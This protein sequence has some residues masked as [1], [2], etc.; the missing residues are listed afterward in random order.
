VASEGRPGDVLILP[1]GDEASPGTRLRP[2]AYRSFLERRGYRV[3]V[4]FPLGAD[5]N[6]LRRRRLLRPLE[7]VRDLRAASKADLVVVYRKTFPGP[8]ARWLRRLAPRVIYE[9]DDAVYLPSRGEPQDERSRARYLANF[10]TTVAAA[11]WVVAGN[12]HLAE[13]A[14]H[15]RTEI[16]PT[17]VDL[18]VFRPR[19][20]TGQPERCV[21]GW[22]GTHGNLPEWAGLLGVFEHVVAARPGVRLKVVSDG[23]PPSTPLPLEVERF[24]VERE[25]ACL[26]AFDIGLMPLADTPWNRGKCSYKALQCMA[27]GLPVVLSP[28]GMNR[29]VVEHGVTGLFAATDEEWAEAILRL[30]DDRELR[31]RL[32][33]AARTVVERSYSLDRV[34]AAMV[35]L[36]DRALGIEAAPSAGRSKLS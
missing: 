6:R 22:I 11:D 3:R 23:D 14:H 27:M 8:T 30:T 34:G 36:V 19:E 26:E 7:L 28:V 13:R 17:G 20:R 24:T 12:R 31:G 5:P 1:V 18:S 10:R 29:E 16:V 32:G 9:F 21:L 33:R 35:E 4:A 25:A 2:L 15:P